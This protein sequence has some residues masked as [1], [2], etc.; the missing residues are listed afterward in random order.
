MLSLIVGRPKPTAGLGDGMDV[1]VGVGVG[2]I[3]IATV[4]TGSGVGAMHAPSKSPLITDRISKQIERF[5]F[6]E[7]PGFVVSN[8]WC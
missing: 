8:E 7:T 6:K 4:P 3:G 1:G 5:A 2:K